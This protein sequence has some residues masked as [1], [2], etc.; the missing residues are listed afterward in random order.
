MVERPSTLKQEDRNKRLAWPR[1][2]GKAGAGR[3]W[4]RNGEKKPVGAGQRL[5]MLVW[6]PVLLRTPS[7]FISDPTPFPMQYVAYLRV[8]LAP[9][10][11]STSNA[12]FS[13]SSSFALS[14][15]L[16]T[17]P[18]VLLLVDRQPPPLH[19]SFLLFDLLTPGQAS[20]TVRQHS[21]VVCLDG[22]LSSLCSRRWL[23][24]FCER[25]SRF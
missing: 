10:V 15:F 13:S 1:R 19:S 4:R 8:P 22:P 6:S 14:P 7:S 9:A 21:D 11:S 17:P 20:P 3:R 12:R 25:Y 24:Q 16:L 18:L 2:E 23:E 5:R